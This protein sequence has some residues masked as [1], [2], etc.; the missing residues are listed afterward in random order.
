LAL[1]T[2]NEVQVDTFVRN[3]YFC[4]LRE[5]RVVTI[6]A[7]KDSVTAACVRGLILERNIPSKQLP[8]H[9]KYPNILI[10][11]PAIEAEGLMQ[12]SET[13]FDLMIKNEDSIM[14]AYLQKIYRLKPNVIFVAEHVSK[15]AFEEFLENG[16]MVISKV[17]MEDLRAIERL[18]LIRKMIDQL[19]FIDKYRPVD[20][21]GVCEKV[22]FKTIR[23]GEMLMFI[24]QEGNTRSVLL[25]DSSEEINARL[26]AVFATLLR[27]AW[28]MKKA[29][30][31]VFKDL[32]LAPTPDQLHS[33]PYQL[34]DVNWK[35][36]S[37][38]KLHLALEVLGTKI[39]YKHGRAEELEKLPEQQY[40]QK[41]GHSTFMMQCHQSTPLPTTFRARCYDGEDLL[42]GT[43]LLNCV[44]SL[45]HPCKKCNTVHAKRYFIGSHHVTIKIEP[46]HDRPSKIPPRVE[47]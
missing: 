21:I 44:A 33:P 19:H 31:V 25:G 24:E 36:Y 43:F 5:V 16:I 34:E 27:L 30:E 22:Y 45:S 13:R 18:A 12:T 28:R 6:V 39:V 17:R 23:Q 8:T 35:M 10:F 1:K 41:L 2:V 42:L 32:K 15:V 4:L 29:R 11:K 46:N 3:D 9:L 38:D 47:E 37:A 14:R 40:V 7:P 20:V 26:K